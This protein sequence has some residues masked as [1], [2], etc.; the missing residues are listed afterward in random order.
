M[1]ISLKAHKSATNRRNERGSAVVEAALVFPVFLMILWGIVGFGVDLGLQQSV[2]HAAS[3][4][5]RDSI[6]APTVLGGTNCSAWTTSVTST[7]QQAL[8]WLPTA[9]KPH[10]WDGT[11]TAPASY[12]EVNLLGAGYSGNQCPTTSS[13][14]SGT[15]YAQVIVFVPTILPHFPGLAPSSIKGQGEVQVQ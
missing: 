9:D 6:S 7:V 2:T 12:V 13:T 1:S 14:A 5:A 3:E 11:G 8:S 4:A 15:T 10:Y